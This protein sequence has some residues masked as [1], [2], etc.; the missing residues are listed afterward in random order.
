MASNIKVAVRCRPLF[1]GERS[2]NGLDLQ[3]RRISLD[4][5]TYD[6]D[7][8][9]SPS[10]QQEDLFQ[11]CKPILEAVVE[12]GLNGTIMV[13][14]QTGTGK[15]Y[16]MIGR[17]GQEDG[18]VHRTI[19]TMLEYVHQKRAAGIES[20]LT[21]SMIEIYNEKLTDML[22]P[23]GKE[24]VQLIAGFPR[25]A[26]KVVLCKPQDG[27]EAVMRGLAWRRTA[28]T[29]MNE[30]SSR[31]HVIFMLD[32]EEMNAFTNEGEVRH[33]FLV[34][35]AGSESI[36]KSHAV[37]TTANEAG[38]INRSLLA[39]KSV[40]LALS[41]TTEANRPSHVPYRDS[42][43]TEI[44]QDSVGGSARTLMIACIS[45]VGRDIEET[46]STLLYAVK[47]KSIRNAT[48]TEKEKLL[49]RL[50]SLEVENQRLRNRLEDRVVERGGYM[51]TKEEHERYTQLEEEVVS[52]RDSVQRLIQT[53]DSQSAKRH[54]SE[55]YIQSLQDKIVEKEAETDEVKRVYFQAMQKFDEQA[56]AIQQA[57][58]GAVEVA[59]EKARDFSSQQ[60]HTLQ[61]WRQYMEAAA[62]QPLPPPP[63]P[64]ISTSSG[65]GLTSSSACGAFPMEDPMK[66]L[67]RLPPCG[68]APSK[69]EEEEG[70]QEDPREP[71]LG[72][73]IESSAVL[74]F[75][76]VL[77]GG[78]G[79]GRPLP[80]SFSPS[81]SSSSTSFCS[82][83]GGGDGGA[84]KA[85]QEADAVCQRV[86]QR[87]HQSFGAVFAALLREKA[88]YHR[89]VRQIQAERRAGLAAFRED[90]QQ[91]M[92]AL[93]RTSRL[94]EEHLTQ[95]GEV[96]DREW[97]ASI[98]TGCGGALIPNATPS[99]SS[100]NPRPRA[101][102]RDGEEKEKEEAVVK[103]T[104]AS[105]EAMPAVQLP[106]PAAELCALQHA[107]RNVY[108]AIYRSTEEWF[109]LGS[110]LPESV[111][112]ALEA[113]PR[114]CMLEIGQRATTQLGLLSSAPLSAITTTIS[115]RGTA[116]RFSDASSSSSA[117]AASS[118]VAVPGGGGG[119][120]G[121]LGDGFHAMESGGEEQ[122]RGSR[123]GEDHAAA[124]TAL[125][126]SMGVSGTIR[127]GKRK[128][129][130]TLSSGS[131]R[132]SRRVPLTRSPR[133]GNTQRT[134]DTGKEGEGEVGNVRPSC[135][136][137]W[138]ST[139]V[140]SPGVQETP[141]SAPSSP[142]LLSTSSTCGASFGTMTGSGASCSSVVAFSST[143][144]GGA[145]RS[146]R[147]KEC[148]VMD[149]MASTSPRPTTVFSALAAPVDGAE[150]KA[151]EEEEKEK[152]TEHRRR[153][154][155]A[156]CTTTSPLCLSPRFGEVTSTTTTT[157][158]RVGNTGWPP[159]ISPS[160]R[161]VGEDEEETPPHH[162]HHTMERAVAHRSSG[163]TPLR[164]MEY[165]TL[166][167]TPPLPPSANEEEN[168]S[169]MDRPRLVD[170][171]VPSSSSSSLLL[172]SRSLP[173]TPTRASE[174]DP[175]LHLLRPSSSSSFRDAPLATPLP[176]A[177]SSSSPLPPV[178]MTSPG[179]RTS[180]AAPGTRFAP[181]SPPCRSRIGGGKRGRADE[182]EEDGV[183]T[184]PP[185]MRG[186]T[187][188]WIPTSTTRTVAE[189]GPVPRRAAAIRRMGTTT[190]TIGEGSG[191]S[192]SSFS[193]PLFLSTKTSTSQRTRTTTMPQSPSHATTTTTASSSAVPRSSSPRRQAPWGSAPHKIQ[194]GK[195]GWQP[196][197]STRGEAH[198]PQENRM[199]KGK[200]Q[201]DRRRGIESGGGATL[202]IPSSI[203]LTSLR[204]NESRRG[205]GGGGAPATTTTPRSGR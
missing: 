48:N 187:S 185:P 7:Y 31:S 191:T 204:S 92:T 145:R 135:L 17:E 84:S 106:I 37:G 126:P 13:Y 147:E 50:R 35:L 178:T 112:E 171:F 113:I 22:S 182:E 76:A 200:G 46:K 133:R 4:N 167:P 195:P 52:L 184:P 170:S 128:L 198:P 49:I 188:S 3:S 99:I 138:Y 179:L 5:K 136:R 146:T 148:E 6:P 12:N 105:S 115:G 162:H 16:T 97:M 59:K 19:D 186:E 153:P 165:R 173:S 102:A 47:A 130:A 58:V 149:S 123:I 21:L 96:M 203:R 67:M 80:M 26:T 107:S 14:G 189:Q 181:P 163:G 11:L 94:A 122:G 120:V 91:R 90:L 93:E 42:R 108:H 156:S 161:R 44:L 154:R 164:R 23:E 137:S 68:L 87:I 8:T 45:A 140:G 85:L 118:C 168:A 32:Y 51:I 197:K 159:T 15:T 10:A 57:V 160:D 117:S 72:H 98:R 119:G 144:F 25:N 65:G 39:L 79:G 78:A 169:E 143:T 201:E 193:S 141:P 64:S 82:G 155:S 131:T 192:S 132:S 43:L 66:T 104:S 175:S 41:N 142:A 75:S 121:G 70:T 18:I 36:K 56:R 111:S 28:S 166:T 88:V 40:F 152:D 180:L 34:D 196:G 110:S 74:P 101:S 38:K 205:G 183:T 114:T 24:E 54:I 177:R 81:T 53:S 71:A 129:P 27:D 89:R 95:A 127:K 202:G 62:D 77:H 174:E 194:E 151:N 116:T 125:L 134:S 100:E 9:F 86:L 157:A 20:A 69:K 55:S 158:T 176:L 73:D 83:G 1:E 33:L 29:N 124:A 60:Y 103:E 61:T 190:T 172:A 30:R 199:E 63:L 139:L 109:P 2:A 150:K